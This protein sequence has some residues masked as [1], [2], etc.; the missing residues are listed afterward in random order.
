MKLTRFALLST[1]VCTTKMVCIVAILV[2][3]TPEQENTL[4]NDSLL[5]QVR[6]TVVYASEPV[7]AD[8]KQILYDREQRIAKKEKEL[9]AKEKDLKALEATVSASLNEIEAEQKRLTQLINELK[10]EQDKQL[11]HLIDVYSNMKAQQAGMVLQTLD[12]NIAVRILAGMKGRKAG[13]VL[14]FVE[15]KKAA[16]L[17]EL[18]TQIQMNATSQQK[19]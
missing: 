13:E 9:E 8:E 18:L 10:N 1:I 7:R 6:S 14:S 12:E 15:P 11:Q 16:K 2:L 5:Q 19:K 3:Y 4:H 17:S